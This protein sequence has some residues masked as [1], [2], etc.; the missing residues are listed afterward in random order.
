[1]KKAFKAI[2]QYLKRKRE[3]IDKKYK[4]SKIY[5]ALRYFKIFLFFYKLD[6]VRSIEMTWLFKKYHIYNTNNDFL[7][8]FAKEY[9]N[10][11]AF[12][13]IVCTRADRNSSFPRKRTACRFLRVP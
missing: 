6:L 2:L 3:K 13:Q 5:R 9:N 8:Y 7:Q 4:H 11:K 1:M 10:I 12:L